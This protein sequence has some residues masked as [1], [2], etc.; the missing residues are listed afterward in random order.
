MST[1]EVS[2]L[3]TG[4]FKLAKWGI[5]KIRAQTV[6]GQMKR[7]KHYL[8]MSEARLN[9]PAYKDIIDTL[10]PQIKGN[11]LSQ[12]AAL[13]GT[14]DQIRRSDATLAQAKAFHQDA[15]LHWRSV[16]EASG[17][18]VYPVKLCS[19][20]YSL[21]VA[22]S[23]DVHSEFFVTVTRMNTADNPSGFHDVG[24]EMR[25]EFDDTV[26]KLMEAKEGGSAEPSIL[27]VDE[28]FTLGVAS[29]RESLMSSDDV[30]GTSI[31]AVHAQFLRNK[32]IS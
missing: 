10:D 1:A 6:G 18:A 30:D 15:K 32:Y 29:L 24:A 7:G 3:L 28:D 26:G 12:R 19:D 13:E 23:D 5:C 27:I 16:E 25:S 4:A 9:D 2:A 14:R 31:A 8:I 20:R 17:D 11:L 22:A 21:E